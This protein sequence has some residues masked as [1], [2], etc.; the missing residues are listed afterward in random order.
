MPTIYIRT[1]HIGQHVVCQWKDAPPP[2]DEEA[3]WEL[4]A[5][6]DDVDLTIRAF[7]RL[8]RRLRRGN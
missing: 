4:V 2:W 7:E 3:T 1:D 8:K 6:T 5:E